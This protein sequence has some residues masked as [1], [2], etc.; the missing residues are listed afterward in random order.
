MRYRIHRIK[1]AQKEHFRWAPHTG[2]QAVIK[3]RDYEP[4]EEVEAPSP[5]AAWKMLSDSAPLNP[6]DVL[7]TLDDE[8]QPLR[9][10]IYKYI[11]FEP[12]SWFIPEVKSDIN[13]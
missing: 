8:N 2:G 4:A 5:Y 12:A 1:E 9:L 6:G 10:E 11:G 7:E 13:V 3:L